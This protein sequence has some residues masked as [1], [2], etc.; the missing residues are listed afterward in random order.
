MRLPKSVENAY[1]LNELPLALPNGYY[2]S[3]SEVSIINLAPAANQ[4]SH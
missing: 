2:V 4:I 3:L 1:Q